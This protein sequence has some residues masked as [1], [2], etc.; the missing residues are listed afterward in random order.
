MNDNN[1]YYTYKEDISVYP[2]NRLTS[3][4]DDWLF[5]CPAGKFHIL[6]VENG[7]C[8]LCANYVSHCLGKYMFTVFREGL[9]ISDLAFSDDFSGW[10]I[11]VKSDFLH[12]AM[13]PNVL[14]VKGVFERRILTPIMRMGVDDF[15]RVKGYIELLVRNLSLT[16]HLYQ[17]GLI[18][19][20]L[21]CINLELWDITSRMSSDELRQEHL[22]T[23]REKL[24]F[25]YI[26]LVHNH[27]LTDH[28]VFTYAERLNVSA[29]HLTRV[30]KEVTG[31]T[32]S[33]WIAET[34]LNE[35]KCLLHHPG[36]SVQSIADKVNFSDQAALNKFFKKNTG[37]TPL[38]YRR[39]V[40]EKGR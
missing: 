33:E 19:N 16:T 32:A 8:Q 1:V 20:I 7:T 37:M 4:V 36:P 15:D 35:I 34:L 3:M 31:K 14:P 22:P 29:A 28:E 25:E 5:S 17:Y 18:Q 27:C 11:A 13:G 6:I 9:H 10:L 2:L 12:S 24:A 39:M 26:R 40:N 38:E 21:C 23:M 30:L